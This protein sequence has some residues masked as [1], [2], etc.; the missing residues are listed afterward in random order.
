MSGTPFQQPT[1]PRRGPVREK[2]PPPRAHS[3]AH[4]SQKPATG[5]VGPGTS[6]HRAPAVLGWRRGG[7]MRDEA[8]PSVRYQHCSWL[9]VGTTARA[10]PADM[11]A[12]P[13]GC[14][15]TG[16][17]VDTLHGFEAA[18]YDAADSVATCLLGVE[19]QLMTRTQSAYVGRIG[20]P[21]TVPQPPPTPAEMA[22][23]CGISGTER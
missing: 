14:H 2:P 15:G 17:P 7:G 1:R 23:P 10:M 12:L 16:A 9:V 8:A 18:C 19:S 13:P 21:M 5:V 20:G 4:G 22:A 11:I 3:R 6:W